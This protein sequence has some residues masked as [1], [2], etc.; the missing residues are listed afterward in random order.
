ME[1]TLI[2]VVTNPDGSINT[3]NLLMGNVII[4]GIII[5]LVQL[6]KKFVDIPPQYITAALA[7]ASVW[8]LTE[9]LMPGTSFGEIVRIAF[10]SIG[11]STVIHKGSKQVGLIKS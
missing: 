4:G 5:P 1:D 8:V 2:N 9:W 6:I 3:I 11:V 7:I 10:T